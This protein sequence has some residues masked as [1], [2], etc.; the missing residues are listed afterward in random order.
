[1]DRELITVD[2]DR[3][4]MQ[5]QRWID[6]N[7]PSDSP[8]LVDG[9]IWVDL[10]RDGRPA[11]RVVWFWKLDRDPEIRARYPHG[12]R[13]FDHVTSTIAVRLSLNPLPEISGAIRNGTVVASFGEGGDQ[14]QII[15][16]R[17]GP[18][19]RSPTGPET[20]PAGGRARP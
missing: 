10:V 7:V 17:S 2:H 20:G 6:A 11:S 18:V 15:R 9:A 4:L 5:A 1:M 13:D 16:I 3:P 19:S 12:W 8:M 14:V